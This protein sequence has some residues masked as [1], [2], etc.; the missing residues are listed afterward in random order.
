MAAPNLQIFR[1]DST[2]VEVGTLIN[3]IDFGVCTAGVKT[4]LSYDCLLFNDKDGSLGSEDVFNI[5]LSLDRMDLVT[6]FTSN[7]AASQ[8]IT[9]PVVPILDETILVG[10]AVWTRV[11]N[12]S[13]SSQYATVYTLDYTTGVLTFG[14]GIQGSIPSNGL[15]VTITFTPDTNEYGKEI[16][17]DLWFSIKSFGVVTYNKTVLLELATK[18]SNAQVS[19][20]HYNTIVSITGVW[21]NPSKTGTNY[22]TG[23]SFS[24]TTGYINLGTAITATTPYVEYVYTVYDD[25]DAADTVVTAI[26]KKTLVG[27]I[28]SRNA[29]R[30]QLFL[31]VPATAS[32]LG[33]VATKIYLK[34]EY[35]F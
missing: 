25:A 26:D 33:G 30:L 6:S 14:D 8:T 16:D 3:P 23:G 31:N 5:E 18:I 12:F 22:Y 11:T 19:V 29:K 17:Q 21:D 10:T 1:S 35:D 32:T 24:P 20:V 4:Q 9:L 27:R 34:A 2:A 28:P 15:V 7:G 13:S